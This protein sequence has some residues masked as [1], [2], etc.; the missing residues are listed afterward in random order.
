MASARAP[1]PRRMGAGRE[2]QNHFS[3]ARA[4]NRVRKSDTDTFRYIDV[5]TC[6]LECRVRVREREGEERTEERGREGQRERGRRDRR[7]REKKGQKREGEEG[8]EVS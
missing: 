4:E 5:V 2:V 6:G 1:A 3:P 8:A 7:E